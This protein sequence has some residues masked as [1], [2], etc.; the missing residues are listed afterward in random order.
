MPLPARYT[1]LFVIIFAASSANAAEGWKSAIYKQQNI[2]QSVL[3][4]IYDYDLTGA[5]SKIDSLIACSPEDPEPYFFRV[6]VRWWA[7][8][9]ESNCDS[10]KASFLD[11]AEKAIEVAEKRVYKRGD[12]RGA[13]F[14][15][16]ASYGYLARYL[17]LTNSWI[18][19]Y[20]YGK[21]AKNIFADMLKKDP[22]LY[23]AD[24]A[25]G[26]YNY[27]ADKL[28][29]LLKILASVIGLGGDRS[30]GI[31]Q[32]RLT[33]DSG[34]YSKVEARS[35]LGYINLQME[36]DYD[37][38]IEIFSRLAASYSSNPVF[39]IMLSTSYR[40]SGEYDSAISTC[41]KALN[42]GT[43]RYRSR[44][45]LAEMHSELAYCCMLRGSFD[46]AVKEYQTCSTLAD[47]QYIRES[48]WIYYNAGICEESKRRYTEAETYYR[49]V[50]L[51]KDYFDYHSLALKSI[52]RVR[53]ELGN[54]S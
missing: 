41:E 11:A 42:D 32:L 18:P 17:L 22:T 2:Y 34:V 52:K 15:L 26:A 39:R 48:P 36:H 29:A 14:F 37:R 21:K 50:L 51:C 19:A 31:A 12:D 53:I 10:I 13:L 20:R 40:K 35:L 23:D 44:N 28:P 6:L 4:H 38:A 3:T 8:A 33:A 45:Q 30:L 24:L 46:R 43:V 7:Y 47:S 27:Y 16:G 5:E 54:G 25:I 49:R 9:G 1:S